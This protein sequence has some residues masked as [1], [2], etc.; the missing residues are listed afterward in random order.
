MLVTHDLGDVLDRDK[1]NARILTMFADGLAD[2]EIV[3][4]PP[5][6]TLADLV[7]ALSTQYRQEHERESESHK[8]G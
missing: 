1:L 2:W 5:G 6:V 4:C 8:R 3:D 7:T